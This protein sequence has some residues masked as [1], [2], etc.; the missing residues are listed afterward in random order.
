MKDYYEVLGVPKTASQAEIKKAFYEHARTHHPDKGGDEARFKE[1]NEAYQT[2][3]D[4]QKRKQYDMYGSAGA[5]GFDGFGGGGFNPFGGG[6]GGFHVNFEDFDMGDIFSGIFE[7]FGGV[8]KGRSIEADVSIT[9]KESLEGVSKEIEI[10]TYKDGKK[11]GSRKVNVTIPPGVDNGSRLKFRG[12]GEEL[13]NGNPGDLVVYAKVAQVKGFR[14]EGQHIITEVKI[15]LSQALLGGKHVL[16]G[17]DGDIEISIPELTKHKDVITVRG[18]GAHTK[19]K[20]DL[21]VV[22][23]VEYGKLTKETKKIL[24]EL[25]GQK[26]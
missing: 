1:V 11:V 23:T 12:Y 10:P 8:R 3:S 20:G 15:P 5:Q 25:E 4:E 6:A 24:E 17:W 18:L 13:S 19:P 14:K 21:L 26:W 16:K 7:G 9:F 22:V 2:L